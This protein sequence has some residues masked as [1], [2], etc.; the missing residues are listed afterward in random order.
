MIARRLR[1]AEIG[2]RLP[3][4][5]DPPILFEPRS[6]LPRAGCRLYQREVVLRIFQQLSDERVVVAHRALIVHAAP[7]SARLVA[8]PARRKVRPVRLAPS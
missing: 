7:S 1:V 6:H 8:A 2:P 5:E 4:R 3:C